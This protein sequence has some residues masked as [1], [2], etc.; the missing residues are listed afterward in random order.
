MGFDIDSFLPST[1]FHLEWNVYNCYSMLSYICIFGADNFFCNFIN[2]Q[3]EKNFA[4]ECL[5]PRISP[6][7]GL[8]TFVLIIR[9]EFLLSADAIMG[10]DSGG[11]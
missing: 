8:G 2:P 9:L 5:I 1:V 3:I 4:P 11:Y 6:T 10:G 7:P